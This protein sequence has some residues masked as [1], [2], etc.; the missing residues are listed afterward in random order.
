MAEVVLSKVTW[1]PVFIADM[2]V[3]FFFFFFLNLADTHTHSH[4]D[5]IIKQQKNIV[6]HIRH[7]QG[8]QETLRGL[9]SVSLS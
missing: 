6:H 3:D 7:V 1:S 4:T 5:K 9:W 2:S 8:R